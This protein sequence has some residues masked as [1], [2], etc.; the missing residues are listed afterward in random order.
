MKAGNLF[1]LVSLL[2]FCFI[3]T[4]RS[5]NGYHLV[6]SDEF[7]YEGLPDSK[8]WGYDTGNDGWG[9]NELQ[10]YTAK[11]KDNAIVGGGV[12]TIKAVKENYQSAPY[13]SARLLTKNKASW[14]Y[15]RMEIRAKLPHGRG[16]WPAIWMLGTERTYGDWPG[17]GEIDIMEH[18]GYNPD[19]AFASVH[20]KAYNHVIGTQKTKGIARKDLSTTFHVY[21][22]EW[23]DKQISI[24]IDDQ[25]YFEF[26][27]EGT[28]PAVWPFDKPFF[29]VLNL[30]IGGNWG[31]KKGV[32][33]KIFPQAMQVDYVR[34]YQKKK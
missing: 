20:T 25:K 5:Q 15:G 6:W 23:S 29:L 7:N 28:G 14:T 33:E 13:T 1:F 22:L 17:S 12:L 21:T 19:S 10:F 18:V 8:K 16:V 27:N 2:S 34:V 9:N 24:F 4:A 31:G 26:N 11:R 3:S 32:D 30:A